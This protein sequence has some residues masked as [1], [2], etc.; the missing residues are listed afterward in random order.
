MCVRKVDETA[1][2]METS[3]KKENEYEVCAMTEDQ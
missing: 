1:T 2:V 3:V